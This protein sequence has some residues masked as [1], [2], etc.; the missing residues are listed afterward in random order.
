MSEEDPAGEVQLANYSVRFLVQG[1]DK[2]GVIRV[3][4]TTTEVGALKLICQK[5]PFDLGKPLI[6]EIVPLRVSICICCVYLTVS[7]IFS[8]CLLAFVSYH[9]LES[10]MV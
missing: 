9:S 5:R 7:V 2:M 6:A 3:D 1:R 4:P 10:H 8:G